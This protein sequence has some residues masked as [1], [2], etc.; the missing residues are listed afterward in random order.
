MIFSHPKLS[1]LSLL[2]NEERSEE[3]TE[4]V[5]K[6]FLK[7]LIAA[8][9]KVYDFVI[10]DTPPIHIMED[11][12]IVAQYVDSS[13]LVVR[14]DFCTVSQIKGD[15]DQLGSVSPAILGCIV[16]GTKSVS[17]GG[18]NHY[19]YGYGYGYGFGRKSTK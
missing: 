17:T 18:E 14:Q 4:L 1:N 13:I 19:G 10:I 16:N 9:S 6:G 5:S 15:L 3:P 2:L 12:S 11:A 8:L 7:V